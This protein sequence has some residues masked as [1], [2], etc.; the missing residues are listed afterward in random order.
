LLEEEII[1][2]FYERDSRGIPLSWMARMRT[3]MAELTPQ[4]SANRMLREY[5]TGLYLK[6]A[7]NYHLRT[8]KGARESVLLCQWREALDSH[9]PK[10]YFGKL[11]VRKEND[12][13]MMSIAVYLD[14]LGPEKVQVQLYAEPQ[15]KAGPE[16]HNMEIAN[17]LSG[18]Q[19]GYLYHA[20]IPA[21][22]PAEHY[23]P[24]IIPCF[25]GASVPLEEN[26]ILWYEP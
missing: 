10:L 8:A 19:N 12:S 21:R 3:S 7:L 15:G 2:S 20:R 13:Y 4:F 6:A 23:T 26:R 1:P 18:S 17:A 16:M 24:R 22:R 14:E 25:E 11:D 5:V 9:W